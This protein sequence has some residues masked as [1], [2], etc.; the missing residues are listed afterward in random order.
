M[1]TFTCQTCSVSSTDIGKHLSST[2]HKAVAY[3]PLHETVECEECGDSNIHL[4]QM[5]RYGLSDLSLLCTDCYVKTGTSAT[6]EYTLANGSII[7]KLPQYYTFRDIHCKVCGKDRKL[8][9]GKPG[10]QQLVLCSDCV[11]KEKMPAGKFISEDSDEFLFALLGIKEY[12][13]KPG[14]KSK[15]GTRKL[16]R[17]GGRDEKPKKFDPDAERRKAHYEN[18][19]ATRL[20]LKSEKTMKAVG[21]ST[22]SPSISRGPTPG[23]AKSNGKDSRAGKTNQAS[24][25]DP[26]DK[27]HDTTKAEA[28]PKDSKKGP[29]SKENVQSKKKAGDQKKPLESQRNSTPSSSS[30]ER[31]NSKSSNSGSNS[32]K[33]QGTE[34]TKG[35]EPKSKS[36][37]KKEKPSEE[38]SVDS[39]INQKQ[40]SQNTPGKPENQKKS[41]KHDESTDTPSKQKGKNSNSKAPK[42]EKG[43]SS[44]SSSKATPPGSQQDSKKPTSKDSKVK[45]PKV[46]DSK[47]K[48]SK[49]KDSKVKDSKEKNPK[50]KESKPK[51]GNSKANGIDPKLSDSSM[52]KLPPGVFKHTPSPTPKLTYDSMEEYFN[53]MCYNLFLE[54]KMSIHTSQK[55]ILTPEDFE[56]E[57]FADQDKKHKQYKLNVLLTPEFLDRYLSKKMQNLK[58]NPF[59]AGQSL[60]LMLGDDIPWYGNI[61]LVDTK[62]SK[63]HKGKPKRG[64]SFSNDNSPKLLEIIVELYKWNRMPL[65]ISTDV[66][67]LKILPV[68]VPVSRV[69]TAMSRISNPRFIDMLLGKTPIRQIFFKNY[70][71]FSRDTFND[72]Q[73]VAVQSVMNNSITVLQG[74]PGTGKTS[75]IYEVI[76]QL[77]ENLNTY[78]ILVVA[79]SNIAIDNIAE[80]LLPKHGNSILRIVSMEKEPEYNREHPL[81]SICLHHRVYDGMPANF[82]ESIREMRR[83]NS[84]LSQAQYKKLLTAQISY[85]DKIIASSR[86]IFTTTV[87]AGGNQLKPIAKMPVVI[88]DEATQSSEPTTLIPLSMN[89][90]EK[91]VF[92][93]DQKQLSSFSQV[94][95][96][97]L[98]LFERILSNGSYKTPHMLDTQYRMHPAISK[99]PREKFYGGLLK[100]GLTP[101]DRQMEGIPSNPVV[102]WDTCGK[103][104]EG[105]VFSRFREDSGLTYANKGEVDYIEKVLIHLIYEKNIKKS[106]IGVVTPYRGQ[107]DLIS[108]TL[109]KND[110]VNP[111]KD[112]VHVEV[113]REDFYNESKPV[114]IH[115][116]SDIMIASIDAFQG[117]EKDFL[118]MSC[119]RSNKQNK[120][121]FL[122]DAR[123][124]NVALTR[125]KYG[126]ILIG[127]VDCLKNSDNLWKEYIDSLEQAG[128]IKKNTDF[129]FD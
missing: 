6:A 91:F 25:A 16:G 68:S 112:D 10:G 21:S 65:P 3:D 29:A 71:K 42:S 129:N 58:K 94:P 116:V 122:S 53:E 39:Q 54:E 76:L 93:G 127:D 33:S 90:V 124:M 38:K 55:V 49:V 60:I 20:S 92:V 104:P 12:I 99:F 31:A 103:C 61:V 1:S 13:A 73:K 34:K 117:R 2:R 40:D 11:V 72:S 35:S 80:K 7:S 47:Q 79:A 67:L 15:G 85:S 77:L 75:T 105:T 101:D 78:P 27:I 107:R 14:A 26:K 120:I 82:Q 126:L 114:T 121:G 28:S 70:L 89:G 57:W 87:V 88:M 106:E 111:E 59:M 50:A 44:K 5:L 100:D 128:S 102:F 23:P 66:R 110:L 8:A 119:V 45:D 83:P 123:R 51:E 37:K 4:L 43:D 30:N 64:R 36:A 56:L 115:T 24:R 97:S 109:V 108:S 48:D 74:P 63:P 118:I 32:V 125:A 9:V 113:D 84:K 95:N 18:E 19:K 81:S 17:K 96:L 46:K 62:S 98:S 52:I 41:V 22:A 86:V 69:F